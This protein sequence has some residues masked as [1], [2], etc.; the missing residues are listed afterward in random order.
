VSKAEEWLAKEGFESRSVFRVSSSIPE[1]LLQTVR[2]QAATLLLSEWSLGRA[3]TFD[4]SAESLGALRRS[5]VPV[6]LA[7]GDVHSFDRVVVIARPEDFTPSPKPGLGLAV[8]LAT[9]LE[10]GHRFVFV[11]RR[12]SAL[13]RLFGAQVEVER[14]DRSDPIEWLKDSARENDLLIF[15]GRD[16][17]REALEGFPG[18]ARRKFLVAIAPSAAAVQ[19]HPEATDAFVAGRSMAEGSG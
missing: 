13:E 4:P 7:H 15:S 11:A 17:V 10:H 9:R 8:E 2:G 14:I 12:S 18:L 16:A 5:H 19:P 6:V 3:E 1:G